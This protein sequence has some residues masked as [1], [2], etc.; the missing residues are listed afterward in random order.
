[1]IWAVLIRFLCVFVFTR[2]SLF[3]LGLVILYF[4]YFLFDNVWLSVSVQWI[5]WKDSSLK[6][7]IMCRVGH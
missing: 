4:M 6:S 3:V 7:P 2:A 5:A 1:M